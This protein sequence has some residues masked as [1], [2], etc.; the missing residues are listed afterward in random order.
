MRPL[1]ARMLAVG[2]VVCLWAALAGPADACAV[3]YGGEGSD[4][5][6]GM[7]NGILFLLGVVAVVQ[8]GFVALFGSIW[9]RTRNLKKHREQFD[10]IEGDG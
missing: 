4:M 7:N 9:Y 10:L 8:T 1:I 5:T 6:T 2:T 3:C